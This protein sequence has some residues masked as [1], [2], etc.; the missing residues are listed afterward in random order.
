MLTGEPYLYHSRLSCTLNLQLISLREV[1]DAVIKEYE[2]GDAPI[3]SVEGFMRQIIGWREFVR[4]VYWQNMLEYESVNAL[5]ADLPMPA[6][7]W[8]TETEMHCIPHCVSQLI[9]HAYAHH[10]QRLMVLG[11]FSL[12]LVVRPYEVHRWHMTMYMDAID[13]VSLPNILG[14][15]QYA[16]GGFIASKPYCASGN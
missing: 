4:G 8:T 7:V 2:E 16:D 11:L 15:S 6:F 5:G 10:I 14:M 1:V 9:D 3:N 13:W 12:L